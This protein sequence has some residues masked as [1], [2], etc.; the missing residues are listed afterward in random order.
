MYL[1][2]LLLVVVAV[3][4]RLFKIMGK[5]EYSNHETTPSIKPAVESL[6]AKSNNTKQNNSLTSK[7][8]AVKNV[9]SD[10][11]PEIFVKQA[12]QTFDEVFNAFAS[13]QHQVLKTK[14]SE[15][16]YEQFATQ[17]QKRE[18]HNLRQE[19]SIKHKNTE[20]MDIKVTPS[21][22]EITVNFK[23]EQVSAMVDMNGVSIDNPSKL[24]RS[25]QHVW[26]FVANNVSQPEWIITKTDAKEL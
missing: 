3:F 4:L 13:S 12:E 26:V 23:V 17:I 5:N 18:L 1:L 11:V 25:V 20:I 16:L 22:I 24:S 21:N 15:S 10:F 6:N 8:L 2:F 9:Y 14:L 7:I 19:I